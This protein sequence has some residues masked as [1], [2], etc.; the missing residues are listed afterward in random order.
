MNRQPI[1]ALLLCSSR[2]NKQ[3]NPAPIWYWVVFCQKRYR[4]RNSLWQMAFLLKIPVFVWSI[5]GFLLEQLGEIGIIRVSDF[6][7]NRIDRHMGRF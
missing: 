6:A 4:F 2:S 1:K 3:Y 7:G 5:A